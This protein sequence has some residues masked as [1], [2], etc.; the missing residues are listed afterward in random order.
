MKTVYYQLM[1]L[2]SANVVGFYR[3]LE[4]ALAIVRHTYEQYGFD[5]IDDLAM[6]EEFGD[7]EG[8]LVAEGRDLLK[9]ALAAIPSAAVG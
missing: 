3:A 8:S 4:D 7:G 2:T 9:M 6:S 5:G 1:D